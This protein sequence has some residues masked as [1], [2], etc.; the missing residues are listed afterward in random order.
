[1]LLLSIGL[2]CGTR[3]SNDAT[4]TSGTRISVPESC[5]GS[6]ASMSSSTARIEAYSVPCAPDTTASTGPGRAPLITATPMSVA[7]S[8]PAGTLRT[9]RAFWPRDAVAVPDVN[10]ARVSCAPAPPPSQSVRP[11]AHI[12]RFMW[13]FIWRFMWATLQR[14]EQLNIVGVCDQ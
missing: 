12:D 9:P 2:T 10:D 1:M 6:T 13:R 14:F 8:D 11:A 4:L 3:R 7:A 5:D